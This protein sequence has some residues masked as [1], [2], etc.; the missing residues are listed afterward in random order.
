[1][2]EDGISRGDISREQLREMQRTRALGA[3]GL[4]TAERGFHRVTVA[5]VLRHGSIAHATF[6]SHFHGL[7][8][9]FQAL[10][11]EAIG[12]STALM[13]DV[14]EKE[15]CWPDGV[16][17]AIVALLAC[18]DAEPVL[19]RV[20]L[21]ES[22]SAGPIALEHRAREL[23]TLAPLL[24]AG[25]N[26]ADCDPLLDAPSLISAV[27]GMLHDWLVTGKAPPFLVQAPTLA[28]FVLGQY[29][30]DQE[31]VTTAVAGA[32]HLSRGVVPRRSR[33]QAGDDAKLPK[34]LRHPNAFRVRSCVRYLADH[35]GVSNQA[36]AAGIGLDHHGQISALLRRGERE[37]L[38]VKRAGGAGRPNAWTLT[39]E[40]ERA[41]RTLSEAEHAPG[42]P[43]ADATRRSQATPR[44]Y[45]Q[46]D[47]TDID[48]APIVRTTPFYDI[49]TGTVTRP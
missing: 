17:A 14:F 12:R 34:A 36:V 3:M 25:R 22:L 32:E 33:S 11:G 7:D 6:H 47:A 18:L 1:L 28:R 15:E 24:D 30:L 44:V 38:F 46:Q 23:R 20:C 5:S 42:S 49:L 48:E 2:T 4:L 26:Y 39:R 16:V 43:D 10:M 35:P 19:A 41:A 9:C 27:A 8:D 29:Y 37:G 31:A 21:V 13:I 45:N 40:G